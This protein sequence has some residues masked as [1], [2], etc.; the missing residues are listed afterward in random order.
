MAASTGLIF[1][2]T[3]AL[4]GVVVATVVYLFWIFIREDV[5]KT[6][7]VLSNDDGMY[8]VNTTNNIPKQIDNCLA[9]PGD[10]VW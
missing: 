5:Y 1:G 2:G 7:I 4:A 10:T 3:L 9:V 8:A 6:V